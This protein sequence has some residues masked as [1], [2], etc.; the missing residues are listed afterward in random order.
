MIYSSQCHF[1]FHESTACPATIHGLVKLSRSCIWARASHSLNALCHLMCGKPSSVRTVPN[2][3]RFG[4]DSIKL[5]R[6]RH[7]MPNATTRELRLSVFATDQK[8]YTA[9]NCSDILASDIFWR[10]CLHLQK[11]ECTQRINI[12]TSMTLARGNLT[13][14]RRVFSIQ[15]SR[16]NGVGICGKCRTERYSTFDRVFAILK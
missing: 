6:R 12:S 3:R 16:R 15:C 1:H 7:T 8:P 4:T 5:S 11:C 14:S 9:R 10:A 13:F 2:I